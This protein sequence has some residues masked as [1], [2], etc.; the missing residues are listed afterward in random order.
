MAWAE[1]A[2]ARYRRAFPRFESDLTD[3]EWDR[4]APSRTGHPRQVDLHEAVNALLCQLMT[5]CQ[6]LALSPCF[7]LPST[8][9]YYFHRWRV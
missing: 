5:G 1:T 9:Q 6:W 2:R 8:V 3:A 7:P 4:P